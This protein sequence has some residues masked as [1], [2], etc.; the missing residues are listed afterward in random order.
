MNYID[1]LYFIPSIMA[2][3]KEESWV[4]EIG[5]FMARKRAEGPWKMKR[6]CE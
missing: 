5:E 3:K 2:T 1:Y 4:N 6:N